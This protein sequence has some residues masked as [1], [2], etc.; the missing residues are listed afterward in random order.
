MNAFFIVPT[1]VKGSDPDALRDA[2]RGEA[3]RAPPAARAQL[4][5]TACASQSGLMGFLDALLGGGGKK[6]KAPA[7]D[8]CSP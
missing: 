1:S 8:R 4:Q 2:R 7:P 5:G 3:H 6:L